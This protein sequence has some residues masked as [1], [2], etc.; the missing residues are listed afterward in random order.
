MNIY[1][2]N[3]PYSITDQDLEAMFSEYGQVSSASIIMDR[4]T[5]R[6]KG[7]GFIV[8]DDQSSAESAIKAFDGAECGGRNLRV[9]EARPREERR[10]RRP[11]W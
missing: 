7:F 2:G 8:M 11:A 3:L 9:N 1:V 10:N 4:E 6:S 5:N